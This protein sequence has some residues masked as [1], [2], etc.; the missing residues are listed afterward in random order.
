MF[1]TGQI[2]EK[3]EQ[4]ANIDYWTN[5]LAFADFPSYADDGMIDLI[6]PLGADIGKDAGELETLELE[7]EAE[8]GVPDVATSGDGGVELI[9][10]EADD[11]D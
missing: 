8:G 11:W 7:A 9:E 1:E 10:P 6:D 2:E 3:T 4:D 5:R